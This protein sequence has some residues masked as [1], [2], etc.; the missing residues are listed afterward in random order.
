MCL[1]KAFEQA[2]VS[3]LH[4]PSPVPHPSL[5]RNRC[6]L[7]PNFRPACSYKKRLGGK[8]YAT[9]SCVRTGLLVRSISEG[10]F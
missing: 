5:P 1:F 7:L 9:L 2:H 8:T 6:Q 10:R 4:L 3:S